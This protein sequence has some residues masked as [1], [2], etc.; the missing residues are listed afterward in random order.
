MY[1]YNFKDITY[2]LKP[3]CAYV[4]QFIALS[5]IDSLYK[6]IDCYDIGDEWAEYPFENNEDFVGYSHNFLIPK[7]LNMTL[8]KMQELFNKNLEFFNKMNFSY[9]LYGFLQNEK[10]KPE[11]YFKRHD[12]FKY[13][14]TVVGEGW[15]DKYATVDNIE[16]MIKQM[17]ITVNNFTK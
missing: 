15:F 10:N 17:N 9:K 1:V 4:A 7:E 14:G 5:Q 8:E 12:L 6:Q 13:T 11:R 16:N 2:E 3:L